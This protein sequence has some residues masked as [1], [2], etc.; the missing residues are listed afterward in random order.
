MNNATTAA[1]ARDVNASNLRMRWTQFGFN[2]MPSDSN[3][4]KKRRCWPHLS[5]GFVVSVCVFDSLVRETEIELV[6]AL[7]YIRLSAWTVVY[8]RFTLTR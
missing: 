5:R 8:F 3:R 2:D 7:I 6:L 1:F 4:K